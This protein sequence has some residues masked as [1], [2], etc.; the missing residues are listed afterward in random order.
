MAQKAITRA[1]PCANCQCPFYELPGQDTTLLEADLHC[2][3]TDAVKQI[4][5]RKG[6]VL[7]NRGEESSH[8]YALTQGVVKICCISPDG[9]EQIV[10]I[11]SP[12]NMLVGLQSINDDCYQYAAIAAT[13]GSACKISH[14]AMLARARDHSDLSLRLINAL[15]AQ[16]AH[17]RKLMRVMGHKCAAA[18][19]ASFISLIVPHPECLDHS[20]KLPFSRMEM[21]GL[22][23][24]SEETVCRQ[25]AR[26]KRNGVIHAPRGRIKILDWDRLRVVAEEAA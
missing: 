14:R 7:F 16:L 2:M 17:S 20:F 15:N 23:G 26:L 6:E 9:H 24:L 3:I 11:S 19:I 5:F 22:L 21:A 4:S 10:G 18:K 13:E 12:G 8:L 25:M 1:M